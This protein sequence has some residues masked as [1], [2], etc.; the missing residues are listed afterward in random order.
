MKRFIAF[1][2][3][4]VLVLTLCATAFAAKPTATM[5]SKY[6]NQKVRRGKNISFQ[7]KVD[8][9]SYGLYRSGGWI[10]KRAMICVMNAYKG[11]VLSHKD[12]FW[13]GKQTTPKAY[14]TWKT[15]GAPK[16]KWINY[17]TTYYRPGSG[18]IWYKAKQ[19]KANFYIK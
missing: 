12:G 7:Y 8:S 10:Y 1:A 3:V 11:K 9:K 19:K 17:Y 6:K 15:Y 18:S 14:F 4:L 5:L 2:L 16:G 13:A